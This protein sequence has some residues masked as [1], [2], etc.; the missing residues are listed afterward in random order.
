MEADKIRAITEW[1][2][3]KNIKNV[4]S[5][6]GACSYYR[7]FIKDFS[8]IAVPLTDLTRKNVIWTWGP[9]HEESFNKLKSHTPVLMSPNYN[10]DFIITC[11]ACSTG[12]GGVLSQIDDDGRE[13]PIAYHSKR[14]NQVQQN[15][16]VYEQELLSIVE[17]L[18]KFRP[19]VD[20]NKVTLQTDHKALIYLNKQP[21]LNAKQARW[22]SFI[23]LFNYEIK[24]KEG[25][26]N[27]VADALSRQ[28]SSEEPIQKQH[29]QLRINTNDDLINNN[30]HYYCA[31][32]ITNVINEEMSNKI[33]ESQLNDKECREMLI[34]GIKSNNKKQKK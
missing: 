20:G 6:L 9:K 16:S 5:F 24:Y 34:N 3:P 4:Q 10:R 18:K 19:Y 8:K 27:K 22:I 30:A 29:E 17:C 23:N 15:W 14:F 33:H 12:Y 25:K 21:H 11:D 26:S 32:M 13:R 1:P 28:F 2:H 7:K 31:L